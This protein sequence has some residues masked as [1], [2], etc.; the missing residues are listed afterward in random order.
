MTQLR[1]TDHDAIVLRYFQNQN[2]TQVGAAFGVDEYAA[3]K[4]A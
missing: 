3:Q 2:L 4:R 1:S